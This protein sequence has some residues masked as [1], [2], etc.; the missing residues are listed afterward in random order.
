MATGGT[1]AP[2]ARES[3]VAVRRFWPFDFPGMTLPAPIP[4]HPCLRRVRSFAELAT[5]R[6]ADGVTALC[7]PRVLPGDFAAVAAALPGRREGIH[8]LDEDELCRLPLGAAGRA[9]VAVML[10]DWRLLRDHGLDPALNLIHGYA[11]DKHPGPVPTDVFSYHADSATVEADTWLCTYSG[12]PTEG[13]CQ[14]E[15]QRCIDRP[16]TRTAL[17][18]EFGGAEGNG[19]RAFLQE[20]CY[21]LHYVPLPPARPF[22]FGQGTLWRLSLKYPGNPAP[23]FIH[24]APNTAPGDPPR[25]LLIS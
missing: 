19:F 25:L 8:L 9:A 10:A 14:G 20:H 4:D 2:R 12:A 18:R 24:R 11:R 1:P 5:T 22:S 16:E 7:W 6:L 13:L 23:P 3:G 15:A 21:D 17:L